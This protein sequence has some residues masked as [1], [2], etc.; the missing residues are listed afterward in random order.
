MGCCLSCDLQWTWHLHNL[1]CHC[2]VLDDAR[3]WWRWCCR[4]CL[5]YRNSDCVDG[6]ITN[7]FSASL[8]NLT[9]A[10]VYAGGLDQQVQSIANVISSALPM[11]CMISLV[12]ASFFISLSMQ[13]YQTLHDL[14]P[15]YWDLCI[16]HLYFHHLENKEIKCSYVLSI[17]ENRSVDKITLPK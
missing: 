10:L 14:S 5:Q 12:N 15:L 3:W 8:I 16:D 7:N 11:I 2:Q 17:D 4:R 6:S 9:T 1:D 13:W